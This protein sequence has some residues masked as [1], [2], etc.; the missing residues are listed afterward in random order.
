MPFAWSS[1]N[2]TFF[3]VNW[4]GYRVRGG[5]VRSLL[6]IPSL[7]QRQGDFSDWVDAEGN[8]I[9]IYDPATTRIENGKLVRD[10]FMG[11]DGNTP[12]VICPNDPRLRN[13]LALQWFKFL[14][15]PTSP[16]TTSNFLPPA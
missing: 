12:N 11:C 8:L 10:Q 7:K 1:R 6:S 3:F 5:V 4:E 2:K 13:S 14:P 9:P 16:G 15:E